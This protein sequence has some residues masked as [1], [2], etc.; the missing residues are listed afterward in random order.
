MFAFGQVSGGCYSERVKKFLSFTGCMWTSMIS[1]KKLC[2]S[3]I[4]PLIYMTLAFYLLF[5]FL[6]SAFLSSTFR[7][8][9]HCSFLDFVVFLFFWLLG[10]IEDLSS[11]NS[12]IG[13]SALQWKHRVFTT[14]PLRKPPKAL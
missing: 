5:Q 9:K 11:P 14:G 3:H 6:I 4:F 12:G 8:L 13:P 7:V 10:S 1:R 2:M